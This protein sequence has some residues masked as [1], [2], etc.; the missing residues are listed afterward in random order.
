MGLEALQARL[1][2]NELEFAARTGIVQ[3]PEVKKTEV[4]KPEVRKRDASNAKIEV[5]KK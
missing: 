5:A 4:K 1:R 3:E 2:A